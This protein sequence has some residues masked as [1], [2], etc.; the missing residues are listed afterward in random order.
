MCTKYIIINN[1]KIKCSMAIPLPLSK[2]EAHS[3]PLCCCC[4]WVFNKKS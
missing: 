3:V 2:S 4:K 1:D